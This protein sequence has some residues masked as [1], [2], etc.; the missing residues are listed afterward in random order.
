MDVGRLT[1]GLYNYCSGK[2]QHRILSILPPIPYPV[3]P[4]RDRDEKTQVK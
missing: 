3:D 4:N 1:E 2:R